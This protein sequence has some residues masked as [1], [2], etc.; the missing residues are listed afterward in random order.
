MTYEQAREFIQNTAKFG[1]ILGLDNMQALM[2]ELGNVQ[3][4]IPIIHIAGTNGK[5]SVGTYLT[6]MFQELGLKVGRYCSPCVFD[7]L[8]A[9]QYDGRNITKAEYAKTLSQV[10]KACDIVVSKGIQPTVFEIETALAFV[11]FSEMPTDILL[12]ETGMGGETDATNIITKP[13]ACVFTNISYDHMQFLGESL[14]EIAQVKSGI[15]KPWVKVFSAQQLPEVESVL[16]KKANEENTKNTWTDDVNM[17]YQIT[18]IM[19]TNHIREK[20][21]RETHSF[22]EY[23]QYKDYFKTISFVKENELYKISQTPTELIFCYKGITYKT[24]LTGSYQMKNAALAI[25]VMHEILDNTVLNEYWN[26]FLKIHHKAEPNAKMIFTDKLSRNEIILKC[27]QKGIAKASWAGRF[28]VI[29][30]EPLCI[31]DGAHNEDAAKQLRITLE[32]CFTNPSLVYIIGVLADKEYKQI[33]EQMLPYAEKVFTIT[34]PNPRALDGKVLAEEVKSIDNEKDVTF[35]KSVE[36]A[37]ENAIHYARE[38][39]KPIL[40]FGSLSY[41]S[42]FKEAYIKIEFQKIK[43]V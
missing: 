18:N 35:C 21:E 34:P 22:T 6:S 13:I 24:T 33:L 19:D 41:L 31:I 12:L 30:T 20:E 14:E 37:V 15:I 32:N 23:I 27:C 43:N 4:T 9:W 40:A 1:S 7:P 26:F 17:I 29:G 36:L 16:T 39:K 8:E 38:H 3:D 25:D 10:K 28:E 5:G 11:Y 42:A 2:Q